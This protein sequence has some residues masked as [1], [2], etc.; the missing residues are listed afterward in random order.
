MVFYSGSSWFLEHAF[1]QTLSAKIIIFT[2]E[3]M[4]LKNKWIENLAE[5][6]KLSADLHSCK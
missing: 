4:L 6:V 3:N 2:G 1:I 5:L